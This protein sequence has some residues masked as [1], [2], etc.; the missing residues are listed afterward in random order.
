MSK[1]FKEKE[2]GR[3]SK[4]YGNF[5]QV[6][7]VWYQLCRKYEIP[8]EIATL[9]NKDNTID[10]NP[11][12]I[13]VLAYLAGYEDCYPANKQMAALFQVGVSTIEKY[14]KELRWVGFIKTFEEKKESTHTDKRKIY[15]QFDVIN[16]VLKSKSNPYKCMVSSEC[17]PYECMAEPIQTNGTTHINVG[18]DPYTLATNKKELENIRNNYK[19]EEDIYLPPDDYD[20]NYGRT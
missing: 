15:V 2:K 1:E 10:L 18:D 17:N 3:L 4:M 19:E 16:E 13:N 5:V 12:E 6:P 14:L 8:K 20:F 9:K 11:M 7:Y